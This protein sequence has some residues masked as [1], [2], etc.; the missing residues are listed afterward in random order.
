M[1]RSHETTTSG[2]LAAPAEAP[3]SSQPPTPPNTGDGETSK[4][5]DPFFWPV[6]MGFVPAAFAVADAD[7]RTP[8][9][10]LDSG[11]L[12][13]LEV[14]LGVFV[15]CYILALIICL[16]WQGRSFGRFELPGGGGAAPA[17]P[18]A[19]IDQATEEVDDF[20]AE[21]RRRFKMAD[22]SFGS[23]ESRLQA[24][25]DDQ[26]RLRALRA[27]EERYADLQARIEAIERPS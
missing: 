17:D 12:Y 22:E 19:K 11:W 2:P 9:Y 10:A 3:A 26:F 14:G 1:Q 24:L 8:S 13:D 7:E 25:E 18:A 20:Q 16:A 6:L 21:T 4:W 23:L 27:A 15:V 5:P